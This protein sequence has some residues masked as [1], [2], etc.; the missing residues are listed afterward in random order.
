ML[1]YFAFQFRKITEL[2]FWWT[3]GELSHEY[4][5]SN[6][7]HNGY[8]KP[9]EFKLRVNRNHWSSE[10]P[11]DY[12]NT[13]DIS[14]CTNSIH[15]SDWKSVHLYCDRQQQ[16]HAYGHQ[17]LL[18]QSGRFR[19]ASSHSRTSTRDVL[20]VAKISVHF[21]WKCVYSSGTDIGDVDQRIHS[22][23]NCIYC[24]A[25]CRDLSS[26]ESSHNVPIAAS[27]QNNLG[28]LGTKCHLRHTSGLTV[29]NHL[30]GTSLSV[31]SHFLNINS[32]NWYWISTLIVIS[33]HGNS[34]I[35]IGS[36]HSE[37]GLLRL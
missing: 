25:L 9:D 33:R 27:H 21:R 29:R 36:M 10:R 32:L 30:C 23:D 35:G 7:W 14:L 16:V 12:S 13:D 11:I 3:N 5:A 18:V 2:W 28:H 20:F 6:E 34:N 17:L 4:N 22:D 26:L 15:G 31:I 8:W 37:E 1:Y 19:S 24:R